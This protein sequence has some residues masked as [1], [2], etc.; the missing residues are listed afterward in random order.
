M[1]KQ[2][3]SA[4][5]GLSVAASALTGLSLPVYAEAKSPQ[6]Q[7]NAR[8]MEDLN[9]GLI[10]VKTTA[11][12]RDQTVNGVYLSWRLLG[13]ESLENQAFDIYRDGKKIH[14]TGVHDATCYVDTSGTESSQYKVVKQGEDPSSEP[15][16]TPIPEN[17]YAK[18]SEVGNG[19]SLKNSFTYIDIPIQRPADVSRMGDGKTSHYYRSDKDH[20]GGANDASVGD[21]DGDGDYEIVLKWDPSDSKDSAGADFTGNVYIDAYEIDP[22]NDGYKWRIDLGQNV[23]A[24]AHYTQFLVYDFDGDGCAEIAMKTAPGTKDGLGNYVTE[25]GDTEEIRNID[26]TKSYIGTSGRLKG[27]N[28]F[29]QFLTIFEGD[30]G[31]A[32]WTT[33]FIPYEAAE[34][35]YWGDGSAKYNRSERYLAAVAYLDGVHPSI[36][37]CRGY[38]HDSVIRAYNWDGSELTMLWEHVG[39]KSQSSTTLYGQGNH[40][41]SVGDID[42]DGKDEIV[43]GSAA[44]DDDGKTV[45]G[46][47]R[48]GHGDA[49]HMSDFNNDGIQ[50]VFSVKE[51]SAGYKKYA[52]DLR[53]AAT[54]KHFWESGKIVTSDDNG[55]GVMGNIDDEYA[56]EHPNALSLGWDSGHDKVHDLNG[57]DLLAKPVKGGSGSFD[58]SLVYWDGD[59]SRELLDDNI[60]QKYE[61]ETGT[62]R[63]FYGPSDG[64]TLT[65][66]VTNN[67]T[68]RNASLSVDLWGDWREEVIMS[69]GKGKDET[70]ALRIFTSTMPTEYRLTTLMH[71]SQYRLAI[72]WQNVAYNMPPHTSYYIGTVA[73]AEDENGNKLNYLAP[74]TK[75]T[76]V[77]YETESIPVTGISLNQSS[78]E[79][80]K[81]SSQSITANIQPENATRKAVIWTSSN[82]EVATVTNGVV[83]G[84]SEGETTITATTRDGNYSAQCE[85]KVYMNHVSGITLDSDTT[86]VGV[87]ATKPITANIAPEDATEKDIEWK[88]SNTSVASVDS[89]GNITGISVGSAT[90]TA[91]TKDGGYSAS[92][93]VNVYP[94]IT[95][96]VTGENLFETSN[97]DTE[98]KL[99]AGADN[100]VFSQSSA[101]VNGEFHKSFTP[102]TDNKASIS[103]KF[104]T[105]GK[106]DSSGVWDWT[107]REYTFGLQFLDTEGENILTIAQSYTGEGAQTTMSKIGDMSFETLTSVWDQT[108]SS[109]ENPIGR[110]STTWVINLEFDYDN[111]T[112]TASL[113]GM[114]KDENG[115]PTVPGMK[116]SYTFGL[117]GKSFETF[118]YYTE[119]DGDGVIDVG[120]TLSEL[121]Y[122]RTETNIVEGVTNVLYNKGTSSDTAWTQADINDWT[123]RNT[124]TAELQFDSSAENGRIYYNPTLPITSYDATKTFDVSDDA[125]VTYN[126]DW[127]FGKATSRTSNLEYIQFGSNLRIGWCNGSGVGYMTWISTDGGAT[128]NDMDG[129][130]ETDNIFSGTNETFTKNVQVVFDTSTNTIQ[131]LTF[132]GTK[133]EAYTDYKLPDNAAYDSVSVGFQR[134]GKADAGEY[135]VGLDSLMVSEFVEGAAPATTPPSITPPEASP[136]TDPTYPPSPAPTPGENDV[137]SIVSVENNVVETS[138]NAYR[139]D[140]EIYIIG[141][142]YNADGA[143]A[144]V[145]LIPVENVSAG[146][147]IERSIEFATAIE[148]GFTVKICAWDSMSAMLPLYKAADMVMQQTAELN[149]VQAENEAEKSDGEE[150]E[151]QITE[152]NTEENIAEDDY[153]DN[154]SDLNTVSED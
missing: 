36:V 139:D 44:L 62:T 50:E 153:T 147:T 129:D 33:E 124:E 75:F 100:A 151:P 51:D 107:G 28:P 64:Y 97:T 48:L 45:L 39:K 148:P 122:T 128:W 120:P 34:D 154:V 25:V 32:L 23:T 137:I 13:T 121:S 17:Y 26:N 141:A 85:V 41:L 74:E 24:G 91:T 127:Y 98:T 132:D 27:K 118:K 113:Q 5:L 2:I 69:T 101:K 20:D 81:G 71:D 10:A 61:A 103:F 60:I 102:Y 7:E 116:Y 94:M 95:T 86:N 84:V 117:N 38:Y 143:L 40:N 77:I 3:I 9:R 31:K 14:T 108:V 12:T 46:N 145:K 6:Y 16:V 30:T 106:S 138:I 76:K 35:K 96:D 119:K 114:K 125:I 19:N 73:L 134:G 11:D 42:N 56:A 65:G 52:A 63:R 88:S 78:I 152:E 72:A 82:S 59:L 90:I 47:T 43:Y 29:T 58:N 57:D 150:T 146:D 133:L 37:M 89:N 53:V 87:G 92:C 8:V 79:V 21:L 68:K 126:A 18:P 131:S 1:R 67:Y 54:G 80:E 104:N 123:Q 142:L 83:K 55:K 99:T 110:S 15:A 130:G 105:G 4:V 140:D 136:T 22:N 70:P 144:E 111:D 66:G 135:V 149:M 109:G 115:D 49:M 93:T 112:C